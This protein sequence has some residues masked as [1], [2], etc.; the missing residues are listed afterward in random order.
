[1]EEGGSLRTLCTIHG[2]LDAI[3]NELKPRTLCLL[4]VHT[5]FEEST[6]Q[7]LCPASLRAARNG[8]LQRY[9]MEL[10]SK[11]VPQL[12]RLGT[13]GES[14]T[15]RFDAALKISEISKP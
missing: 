1:M 9:M 8:R 2:R 5:S 4:D 13:V 15:R 10:F 6:Y 3:I 7:L 11:E 12:R 14:A